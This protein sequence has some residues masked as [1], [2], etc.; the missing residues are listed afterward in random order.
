MGIQV[1]RF[2]FPLRSPS[3]DLAYPDGCILHIYSGNGIIDPL[4]LFALSRI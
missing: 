2:E 4:H 3:F 1:A